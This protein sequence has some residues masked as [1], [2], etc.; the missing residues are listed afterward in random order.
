MLFKYYF[1]K[2]SLCLYIYFIKFIA[3]Y[4]L[5]HNWRDGPQ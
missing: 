2:L 3:I 5:Y 4:N 1:S